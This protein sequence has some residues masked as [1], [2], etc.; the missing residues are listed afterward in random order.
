MVGVIFSG[1]GGAVGDT[2]T[3]TL[4]SAEP[5]GP[6]AVRLYV[7]D[8]AGV[9]LVEPSGATLPTPGER[10]KSVAFVEVQF[11]VTFVPLCTNVEE[12][13]MVTV[14]AAGGGA[15]GTGTAGDCG[16]AFLP[17][18]PANRKRA[19]VENNTANLRNE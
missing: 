8:S 18:A 11:R 7:V 13:L 16:A 4:D 14:G 6:L 1:A 17:H 2:V 5:P 9:T 3:R 12:A 15:A 10:F 19:R